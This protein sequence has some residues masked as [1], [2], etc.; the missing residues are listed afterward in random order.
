M[1]IQAPI[2]DP[3]IKGFNDPIRTWF[4]RLDEEQAGASAPQP[5]EHGDGC[6]LC[7]FVADNDVRI[8]VQLDKLVPTPGPPD[9]H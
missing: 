2:P 3:D 5:V 1:L 4:A 9:D 8:A 7:A 6:V